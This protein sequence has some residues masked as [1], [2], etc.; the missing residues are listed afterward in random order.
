LFRCLLKQSSLLLFLSKIN[1]VC[2]VLF[3]LGFEVL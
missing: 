1:D 3:I 2:P